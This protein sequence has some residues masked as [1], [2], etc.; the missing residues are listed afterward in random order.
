MYS[1]HIKQDSR[2]TNLKS[3]HNLC[4]YQLTR[5]VLFLLARSWLLW[6]ILTIYLK[7]PLSKG[8]LSLSLFSYQH[9][10]TALLQTAAPSTSPPPAKR[11]NLAQAQ[12]SP[13]PLSLH[14]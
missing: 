7:V 14:P 2:K 12:P 5:T 11:G 3:M 10:K 6:L 13:I 4:D 1:F 8:L 9:R